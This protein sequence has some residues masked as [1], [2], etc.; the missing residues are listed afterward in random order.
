MSD[1]IVVMDHGVV[2]QVGTPEEV[3]ETPGRPVRR[4]LRRHHQPAR[5]AR[6][7]PTDAD[8]AEV[9]LP[10]R[11]RPHPCHQGRPRPARRHRHPRHPA[12]GR[13]RRPRPADDGRLTAPDR[14]RRRPV[15]PR[16]PHPLPGAARRRRPHRADRPT[17]VAD[18]RAR[19]SA[20][21]SAR[22]LA[23]PGERRPVAETRRSSS[24]PACSAPASPPRPLDRG[25]AL[26]AHAI[27]IDGGSTDSGPYYLGRGAAPKMPAEAIAADLRLMLDQGRRRPASPSSSARPG[28]AAPTPASTGSPAWSRTIAEEEGLRLRVAR[29]YSEQSP[30]RSSTLLDAGRIS[31]LAAGR[32]RSTD[33]TLR[34]CDHIVGLLGAEPIIAALD[35]GADVV[36]A[37]RATDTAVIAAVP[38]RAGLPARARPGTRPRRPSAAASAPPTRGAAACSSTVDDDGFTV[39][40]LEPTSAVHAD[41]GRRPHDLRERRPQ[42]DARAVGHPRRH[43]RRLHGARRPAGA[44]HRLRLHARSRTRSSSR[45]PASSAT[46]ASPWPASATRRSSPTIDVWADGPRGRSSRPRPTTCSASTRPTV[47]IE[48]RC[49][50]WNAVL[51]DLDPDPTP[52]REVGAV[53]HRH[54]RRP[55]DRHQG[56]EA[57]QP[58]P[59]PHAAARHG[60]P[61]ELRLHVLAGRDRAGPAATSSSSSTSSHVDVA[62]DLFRTEITRGRRPDDRSR[63]IGDVAELVRSK[64]AGPFWQTLDV[65]LPDDDA[66]RRRRRGAGLDAEADRPGSTGSTPT[67]SASSGCRR[68]GWSRSR[69]PGPPPRAASTTATCTPASSTCPWPACRCARREPRSSSPPPC[70]SGAPSRWSRGRPRGRSSSMAPSAS[71]VAAVGRGR[72]PGLP[73]HRPDRRGRPRRRRRPAAGGGQRGRRLRQHRRRRRRRAGHHRLHH[74]RGPRREHRR[75]GLRPG[76]HGPAPH[77]RRRGDP[78]GRAAGRAGP[79]TASSATTSHGATMG[80]VGWGR[81]GQA[82][83]RRAAAFGMEVIHTARRPTGEPGYVADARRAAG[84]GRR[85]LAPR[86]RSPPA[87][88]HLI[89]AARLAAMRPTA[90]LVNTARGAGRRRGR[91]G[92]RPPRRHDLRRR[93][94]RLRGRAR[95]P[96]PAARPHPAPS[97]S[98]T[99]AAPPSPP[100]RPWPAPPRTAVVDVL[101]GR[102]HPPCRHHPPRTDPRSPRDRPRPARRPP[103]ATTRP[104]LANALDG[105]TDRPG[106]EGFTRPADPRVCP[107]LPP[108]VGYAVTATIRSETPFPERRRPRPAAMAPAVRRWSPPAP[109]PS[110]VVVQDLDGGA[111]CLWGEVNST[112]CAAHGLRGRRHRRPGPRPARRRGA[113]ASATSPAASAWPGAYVRVVETGIPVEV[114]GAALRARRRRPRRPPRRPRHPRRGRSPACPPPPTPSSPGSE[115]LL[116]WVRSDDF[117]PAQLAARRAQH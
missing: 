91:P 5:G 71:L 72:R 22:T 81:I 93:P 73:A 54:R 108:M 92:R 90:V 53:L 88:R 52:P 40:P 101:A 83:G 2:R 70:P 115:R 29:I 6:S 24:P 114:G 41:V 79:S 61:A 98:P 109:G 19:P 76:P 48:V 3:Y 42:P 28:P 103:R 59:A 100:A 17:P 66:Y 55:G 35:A 10:G 8:C 34:R 87:T 60:P 43:R 63:T 112:I 38:L 46:R 97:C 113:S 57:G 117:D 56:R 74:A 106:N 94:R 64:N 21:P 77:H 27:A 84:P 78:A 102:P 86:A 14:T 68:S 25:I 45:A 58:V 104:T 13:H 18:G 32:R 95:R 89:D 51:G 12:R 1:R 37:G 36:I 20:S 69:S 110:V 15:V 62:D 65:F 116:D 30:T 67:T 75:A 105:L 23:Y 33:E 96:P 47:H 49:Y 111:G 99:S 107:S 39:D 50:G 9:A 4:R 7:S 16:R 82:V 44:G 31:P 26:G 80:I 85:R 11:P